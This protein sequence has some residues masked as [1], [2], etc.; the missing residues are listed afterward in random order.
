MNVALLGIKGEFDRTQSSGIRRYMCELYDN[1]AK[2]RGLKITK[3]ELEP[4][5]TNSFTLINM[6]FVQK[7][8]FS[9]FGS[10]DI[11]HHV[12][13]K[14]I[15]PLNKGRATFLT[16]I[17]ELYELMHYRDLDSIILNTRN[18]KIVNAMCGMFYK[19]ILHA[20]DYLIAISE[21][22]KEEAVS[23]GY[24][25]EKIFVVPL[26]VDKRFFKTPITKRKSKQFTVGYLGGLGRRKNVN[27]AIN[28]FKQTSNPKMRFLVYGNRAGEYENLVRLAGKD[29]RIRFMGFAPEDRIVDIYDS[30]DVAVHTTL[31][32]GFELEIIEEQARGLPVII[33]KTSMIPKEVKKYCI[34]AEDESH[35]A[36]IINNIKENGY[37]IKIKNRAI[38]YARTF[39]WK[40]NAEETFKV[41]MKILGI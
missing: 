1:L 35:M 8:M 25:K 16:T 30:F 34:E 15:I 41:Y 21:Q 20:S 10:Y 37:N 23:A 14:P 19:T 5:K 40:R 17:Y 12:D 38:R 39:T 9:S 31:Y 2:I 7:N 3:K 28:A 18:K 27:F 24:P 4:P 29:R 32:A 22:T 6:Y 36:Q 26:G 11:I 33:P 13:N